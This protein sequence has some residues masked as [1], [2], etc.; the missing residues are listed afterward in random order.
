MPTSN[1]I[2]AEDAKLLVWNLTES[3]EELKNQLG[4]FHENEL[5][6]LASD[7]RKREYLGVRVAMKTLLGKEIHIEHDTNGKPSLPD[8]SYHISISHSKNWIAVIAHATHSTGVDIECPT[9]KIQKVCTRFL[10][11]REHLDLSNGK[12]IKQLQLAWSVKESLYKIIGKEA[13]DFAN[14]LRIFPFDVKP[15]GEI[16]AQHIQT[17]KLYQLHYIQNSAYTLVYCVD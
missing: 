5:N 1:F 17:K 11:P 8:G 14:Q 2:S 9:D 15:S 13:V 12:N 10:S 6:G 16:I 3:I 7:K 4:L